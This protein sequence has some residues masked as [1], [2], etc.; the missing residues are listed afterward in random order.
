MAN[1]VTTLSIADLNIEVNH[2]PRILDMRLAERL[3]MK[4]VHSIRPLIEKNRAELEMHGPISAAPRMVVTGSGAKR[5]VIEFWLNEGQAL[6]VC[7]LSR[8]KIAPTI[9]YEVI[10]VYQAFRA[11][12]LQPIDTP[13]DLEFRVTTVRAH[14]RRLHRLDPRQLSLPAPLN[15]DGLGVLLVDGKAVM[16]DA[17]DKGKPGDQIVCLTEGKTL[18]TVR[19]DDGLNDHYAMVPMGADVRP[20]WASLAWHRATVIGRVVTKRR[21]A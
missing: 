9:R 7:M 3:G 14:V 13:P 20:S 21:A 11:G 12:R 5:E 2:E 1:A 8:T 16:F 6:V 18:I 15:K 4:N 10:T 19:G 17:N